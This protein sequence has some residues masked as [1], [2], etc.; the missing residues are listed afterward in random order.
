MARQK[1][2]YE[3]LGGRE[4][5]KAIVDELAVIVAADA[6][7]NKKFAKSNPERLKFEF[8]EQLCQMTGGPCKYTGRDMKTTHK[9]MGI[10]EGEFDA[11]I[12]DLV[13]ALDK[14][15]VGAAEKNELLK[16]LAPMK[17]RI[18]GVKSQAPG[19]PL[20]AGSKPAPPLKAPKP[21][22]SAGKK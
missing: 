9:N 15:N 3:R 8:V 19:V 11:L 7:I 20:P 2:L 22:A 17:P 14:F 4:G 6:R 18:V 12:E 10:T 1:S 13:I 21:L 5:I 16:L